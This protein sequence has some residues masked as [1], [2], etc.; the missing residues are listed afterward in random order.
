[1]KAMVARKLIRLGMGANFLTITGLFLAFGVGWLVF[2]GN[3]FAAG[4][5]LLL[6][7]LFDLLDGTVARASGTQSKFG[8]ILDSSMDRYGD[9]FVFGGILLFYANLYRPQFIILSISAL[10]GS[11]SISYVRARAE[12]EMDHCRVGFWE[13]GERLV[14]IALALLIH[15][16][17][18]AL[19]ILGVGVHWTALERLFFARYQTKDVSTRGKAFLNVPSRSSMAY[20]IK[21]STLIFLLIFWR[22]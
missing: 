8:G 18:A 16:L 15:N 21:I 13:R 7:G 11:F 12:C 4:C 6:S 5:V 3:F 1:M 20:Y 17:E 14:F 10:L 19:W 22:P 9:G 2:H